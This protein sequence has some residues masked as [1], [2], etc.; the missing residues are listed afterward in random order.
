MKG[1]TKI[2]R[3]YT[4]K[5]VLL[6]CEGR[7]EKDDAPEGRLIGGNMVGG[8]VRELLDMQQKLR[9]LQTSGTNKVEDWLL[10]TAKLHLASKVDEILALAHRKLSRQ[11]N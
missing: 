4:F 7:G 10:E 5:S 6:Y 8:T 3:G 9:K 2:L 1:M 11:I